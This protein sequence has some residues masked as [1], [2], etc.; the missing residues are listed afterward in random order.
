MKV[1]FI[2]AHSTGKTTLARYV[3]ERYKLPLL[4]EVARTV[5]AEKEYQIDTMRA[6]LE[7]INSY[8]YDVFYR[9]IAEEEKHDSFVSDRSFDNLAYAAQHSRV[10]PH[11]MRDEKLK[12]YTTMLK[13]KDS[14]I[15]FV[16][17]SKATLRNDGVRESLNWDGIISIDAMIK[18][19]LEMWE[20]KYF[21]V[22]SDN[23]QE[24][25][26]LIDS[27]LNLIID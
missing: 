1:Y 27:V 6:N 4:N 22:S 10:L 12:H 8:Q 16:R 3:A 14:L 7:I 25:T 2:G 24:R 26:Q 23:M 20:L 21:Q 5:L 11:L 18:F 19:L 17:P 9:Q 15:F 13:Q